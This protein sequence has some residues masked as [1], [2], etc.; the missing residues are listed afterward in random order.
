MIYS[1]LNFLK[2]ITLPRS[3]NEDRARREFILNILLVGVLFL[4]VFALAHNLIEELL[5]QQNPMSLF[6][7]SV[8][9]LFFLSLYI[10]SRKGYVLVSA[11]AL[12]ISLLIFAVYLGYS[13]GVDLP[14]GILLLVLT[15]VMAGILISTKVA[16]VTTGAIVL[17]IIGIGSLQNSG[18][19]PVDRSWSANSWGMSETIVAGII[20]S[21]IAIVSW[22]SNRE[23]ER[24][25]V[26]ARKS[27][28][29]LKDERDLLEVRVAERTQ[30]L[31]RTQMEK[32]SQAYRFVEFGRVAS[33]IF[34]DLNNPLAAL[35][36][37][38][39]HIAE[40]SGVRKEL[41]DN[42]VRA[43]HATEHMKKLMDSMR[44]H[45]TQEVTSETF[46]VKEI[47]DGVVEM[48]QSY[49]RVRGVTVMVSLSEDGTLSGNVTA[50]TQTLTNLISNAI[51]S[52][53]PVQLGDSA[54]KREVYV[55][56]E[57]GAAQVV[58]VVEDQGGGIAPDDLQ[59]IFEPFFT[60]KSDEKGLGI[61]LPLAKR[62]VE[63][64]FGGTMSVESKVGEGSR[65]TIHLPIKE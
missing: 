18:T 61:G 4:F 36:L 49:A 15:I 23:I 11:S 27:E 46:S 44:K 17:L 48:L 20:L 21:I 7:L 3:T 39:E 55:S 42:V 1:L 19:I 50:F 9:F 56:C 34:H 53:P 52:Y 58:I 40:S 47:V 26:R 24:S 32:M 13:W 30:E 63:K 28:A 10:L 62:I 64:D 22:L 45:L 14:A 25:L 37:N 54:K 59:K 41:S 6:V 31:Q 5:G 57:V 8:P 33:G 16:F 60:T 12:I 2:K 29:E 35:S 51:E 38:I 43:K 65:F